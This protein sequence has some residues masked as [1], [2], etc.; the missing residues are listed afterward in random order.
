MWSVVCVFIF[1]FVFFRAWVRSGLSFKDF[2][3]LRSAFV[4]CRFLHRWSSNRLDP[5]PARGPALILCNHTCSADPTFLLAAC[6]RPISILVAREHFHIH[7][8]AHAVLRHLRCIPVNRTGADPLA[9]RRALARL[10]AG[11]LVCLFPEGNLS[12]VAIDRL[13]P[14]KPGMAYLALVT[15]LPVYPVYIGGGPRTDQ[16]LNSW[17]LPTRQAVHVVFGKPIVLN[18]YYDRPRTRRLIDEVSR[19]LMGKVEELGKMN[20]TR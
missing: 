6:N 2:L 13:R 10:A 14:A 16:L 1:V 15:R 18:H 11:D 9:L 3:V 4:Y 12:G 5:F 8:L 7:P 19:F 20:E 17:V